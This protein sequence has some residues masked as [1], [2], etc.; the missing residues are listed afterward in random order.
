[1]MDFFSPQNPSGLTLP[2]SRDTRSL[3]RS[4]DGGEHG[5]AGD[6]ERA[7]LRAA[8]DPTEAAGVGAAGARQ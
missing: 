6:Q 4:R 3:A 1:M 2:C 5:G 7:L 8:S